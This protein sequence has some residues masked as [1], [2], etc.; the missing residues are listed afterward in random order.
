MTLARFAVPHRPLDAMPVGRSC[1]TAR[2]AVRDEPWYLFAT[3]TQD[4]IRLNP[5][6]AL[7]VAHIIPSLDVKSGGVPEALIG[8]VIATRA[9]A[10]VSVI[11]TLTGQRKGDLE[12]IQSRIPDISIHL[13]AQVGHSAINVSPRLFWWLFKNIRNY[14]VVHIH[15]LLHPISTVCALIAR[16]E[17]YRTSFAAWHLVKL[18]AEREKRPAKRT[19]VNGSTRAR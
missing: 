5:S 7:R 9:S 11:S 4:R 15:T 6:N 16:L 19:Y 3:K 18:R 17:M 13:F 1:A 2:L 8:W 14:D 10:K 12:R